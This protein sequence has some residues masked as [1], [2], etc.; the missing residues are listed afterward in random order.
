MWVDPNFNNKKI[1]FK[2]K[3]KLKIEEEKGSQISYLFRAPFASGFVFSAEMIDTL[4][5]QCFVKS[6]LI[7]LVRLMLGLDQV[8][9]LKYS[10][11]F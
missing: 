4:L 7:D 1:K 8:I 11:I 9:L 6:Y 3:N 10:M 2:L 5:Y